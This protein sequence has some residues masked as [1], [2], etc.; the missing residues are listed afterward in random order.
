M[1][2]D[3]DRPMDLDNPENP[4]AGE[5]NDGGAGDENENLPE[6]SGAIDLDEEIQRLRLELDEYKNLYLRKAAE[7][8]NFRKRK[9]QEFSALVATAEE[10]LVSDLLPVLDDLQRL[11]ATAQDESWSRES[12][13]RGAQMIHDKMMDI[14]AARGLKPLEAAGMPFDP[15]LH[16]AL[17]QQ[18]ESGAEPGTVLQEFLRGYRL[19]DK[20]IRH[21]QVVVSA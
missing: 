4:A 17:M 11:L 18:H 16:E 12:F 19:G 15:N 2:H 3:K 5:V 13:L 20:I 1:K 21:A 10:S 6:P 9:Q 7:F 14:L 8:E